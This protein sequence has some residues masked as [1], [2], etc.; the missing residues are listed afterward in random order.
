MIA[1]FME[2]LWLPPEGA[3]TSFPCVDCGLMTGNFCDGGILVAYDQCFAAERV[4]HDYANIGGLGR[5]RTPLC[6][7]CE[8]L[9]NY[10]R[11]CRGVASCTPPNRLSHVSGCPRG[12]SR[13]IYA[14]QRALEQTR[15][16]EFEVRAAVARD[17][18][19]RASAEEVDRQRQ[20]EEDQRMQTH[21]EEMDMSTRRRTRN[22]EGIEGAHPQRTLANRHFFEMV[23]DI[24]FEQLV[25]DELPAMIDEGVEQASSSSTS[26]TYD[27]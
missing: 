7:Y 8:T 13:N 6:S 1:N 27:L 20:A 4:P 15:R 11:F 9:H 16:R 2:S 25:L 17:M 23:D 21:L 18:A 24:Q 26:R 10:C 12:Q 19:A 5:Q 22:M 14:V 3:P